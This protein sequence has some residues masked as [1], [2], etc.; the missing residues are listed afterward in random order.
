M[1][2]FVSSGYRVCLTLQSKC[3][4]HFPL[5]SCLLPAAR[6]TSTATKS[7]A[8]SHQNQRTCPTMTL[9]IP[10]RSAF[11]ARCTMSDRSS[12]A[13]RDCQ[14]EHWSLQRARAGA[15]PSCPIGVGKPETAHA[16]TPCNISCAKT[17]K[18]PDR[19]QLCFGLQP[20][21][22]RYH[23]T[24]LVE[25]ECMEQDSGCPTG[26]WRPNSSCVTAF[27]LQ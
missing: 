1:R 26:Q 2:I 27:R 25:A 11:H 6:D 7:A 14:H 21:S 8:H 16:R 19:R 4:T 20:A 3:P 9:Y 22:R 17:V 24:P 12:R 23:I 5:T 10:H 13:G 18:W 15:M